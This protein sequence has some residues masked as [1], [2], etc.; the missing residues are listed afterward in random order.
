MSNAL[1]LILTIGVFTIPPFV[2]GRLLVNPKIKRWLFAFLSS[3]YVGLLL[4]LLT[5][6]YSQFKPVEIG[7]FM[8]IIAFPGT[9]PVF[10]LFYPGAKQIVAS[11]TKKA[12]KDQLSR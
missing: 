7:L 8:F 1:K 12:K 4:S 9:F 3:L 2:F 10:Y 6:L 11:L 5:I